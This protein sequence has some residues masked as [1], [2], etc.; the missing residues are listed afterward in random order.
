[1]R[2]EDVTL[3]FDS[4]AEK[5]DYYK[6]QNAFYYNSIKRTLKRLVPQDKKI[7]DVGTATGQ[8]LSFLAP[9]QGVGYDISPKMIEIAKK[10]NVKR[11]NLR[12]V[13][14]LN[15]I[16]GP[17]DY[18]LLIDVIEHLA[19]PKDVFNKFS[20]LADT[21]TLLII[22]SVDSFFNPLLLLVEKLHLKMPE[23]PHRRPKNQE[24]IKIASESGFKLI[25]K[26]WKFPLITFFIFK[27][28]SKEYNF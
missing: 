17:F 21:K 7:L 23:G 11:K 26:F 6:R 28:K 24:I 22:S 8:I 13:T 18:I 12:F 2:Q 27:K 10:K 14:S 15:Q 19:M 20:H 9:S 1:M 4:I 5:Y 25:R 16:S 3:H